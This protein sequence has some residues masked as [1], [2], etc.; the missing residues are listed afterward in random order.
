[1]SFY[2]RDIRHYIGKRSTISVKSAVIVMNERDEI[3]LLRKQG[4][5]VWSIPSGRMKPGESAVD[6][7]ARELWEESGQTA[8]E[9]RLLDLISGPRCMKKHLNGDEEYFVVGVYKALGLRSAI[10]LPSDN[11][12]S[13]RYFSLDQLPCMDT[14]SSYLL[15]K[16]EHRIFDCST[17]ESGVSQ[18]GC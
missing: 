17:R 9:M 14:Q 6:T 15:E 3:L 8:R 5:D 4:M 11:N 16:L 12:E 10:D 2:H 1:M 13:L 7:A 18:E